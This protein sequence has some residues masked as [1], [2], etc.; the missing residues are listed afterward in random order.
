M[1]EI[2]TTGAAPVL[3]QDGRLLASAR[4]PRG[5]AEA[6]VKRRLSFLKRVRG[7]FV[8]GIGSGYHIAALRQATPAKIVVIEHSADLHAAVTKLNLFDLGQAHVVVAANTRELR[9]S[10]AVQILIEDSYVVLVHGPSRAGAPKFY[11]AAH[12]QLI[13]RDWGALNWAW[14]LKGLPE[15]GPVTRIGGEGLLTIHDLAKSELVAAGAERERML[16]KAL[17]ELVK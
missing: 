5:E 13:G 12:K 9:A 10:N 4:D 7:V 11:A 14:K 8:L 3:A 6:W 15:L 2:V 1:I 17:K 16:V